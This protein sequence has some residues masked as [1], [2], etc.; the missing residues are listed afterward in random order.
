MVDILPFRGVLYNCDKISDIS[1]VIS[2]PYDVISSEERK[3]LF[4]LSPYNIVNLILPEERGLK[5]RYNAARQI[6]EEWLRQKIL[7]VDNKSSF[8]IL[9][10]KYTAKGTTKK[11]VGFFGITKVEPYSS[12]KIFPH[13]KTMSLP[14]KDRLNLLRS[15]RTNFE[16]VYTIYDD[17]QGELVKILEAQK[18]KRAPYLVT[19]AQYD[20]S[21]NFKLWKISDSAVTEKIVNI[22]KD[23]N[24]L[25]ADGHHRYETSL[26]YENECKNVRYKDKNKTKTKTEA[27]TRIE[28]LSNFLPE[29]S[30]ESYV[31]T[32]YVDSSQEGIN[33]LPVHRALKFELYSGIEPILYKI[34]P[35]FSIEPFNTPCATEI[36]QKLYHSKSRGKKTFYIYS[37]ERRGCFATLKVNIEELHPEREKIDLDYESLDVNIIHNLLLGKL[38]DDYHIQKIEF[39]HSIDEVIKQVNTGFFDIAIIINP[40][41]INEIIKLAFKGILLPQKSTYFHPKPASG[42]VIYKFDV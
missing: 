23:K 42:L 13:E 4:R 30:P 21:L 32:L 31:L 5:N 2:P 27:E 29:N 22:M 9:E 39:S 10:E 28:N 17:P 26:A 24:L 35:I 11:L 19:N 34:S 41:S 36:T 37:K 14:K 20:S 1:Y 18:D 12:K 25:I 40:L 3:N 15:C 16:P 38:L 8:Y 33:V 6:L 7:I